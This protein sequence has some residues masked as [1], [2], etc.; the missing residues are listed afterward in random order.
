MGRLD[1]KVAVIVGA[2]TGIGAA[3]AARLA[4][5]GAKVVVGDVNVPAAEATAARIAERG[6]T[7]LAVPVDL[8]DETSVEALMTAAVDTYGGI[9]VL[10]NNA[11]DLRPEII[12]GDT[13]LVE[14][15][16]AVWD[17]T[18][19]V[20]LRGFVVSCQAAIPRMLR[21]GGGAI[22]MTSSGA[23]F[24]GEPVRP[25]YAASKAGILAL[26]R[27]VASRWGREGIRANAIAPGLVLSET[28]R[29]TLPKEFIDQALAG[30]PSTRLGRPEDIA[31]A[32]AYL[33]SQDGEWING[34]VLSV[35]GGVTMR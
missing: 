22:I 11:A 27:H 8:A 25:A 34:Q 12:G 19:N 1:G 29:R 30:T 7:A 5:E 10:H 18:L 23:A 16:L 17:R 21:R 35:D 2:G 13:D 9:D 31:G 14:L 15:D 24:I 28:A 20:N 33:A 3:T 6:G 26:V 32:V 4:S